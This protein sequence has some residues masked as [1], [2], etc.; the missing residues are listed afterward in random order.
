ML[1]TQKYWK[2]LKLIIFHFLLGKEFVKFEGTTCEKEN[3]Y[4]NFSS[5]QEAKLACVSDPNCLAFHTIQQGCEEWRKA[6][7]KETR[8][9]DYKL[10]KKNSSMKHEMGQFWDYE[11]RVWIYWSTPG[12]IGVQNYGPNC[13]HDVYVK[14]NEPG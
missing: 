14:S 13:F 1:K 5:F 9:D 11:V 7:N 10:C 12:F 4:G 6:D 2:N 8:E 3:Q